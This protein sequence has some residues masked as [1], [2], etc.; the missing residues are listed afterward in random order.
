[1]N[2][3]LGLQVKQSTKGTFICQQKYIKELLKRF[4]MEASKVIDTPIASTSRLDMDE[5]G[6]SMNQTIYRSI[7]GKSTSGMAHFIGSCIIS[8]GTRKKNSM[9]LSTVKAEYVAAAS[10]CAKLLWIKQQLEDFWVNT[11]DDYRSC[12]CIAWAVKED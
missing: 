3:F 6:S 9:T 5:A 8:W 7:I 2:F 12:K 1:M 11:H 4:D 10:Y